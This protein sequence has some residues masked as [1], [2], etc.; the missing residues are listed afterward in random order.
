[1]LLIL[2]WTTFLILQ[3]KLVTPSC[4]LG[5]H[6]SDSCSSPLWWMSR[7]P[8]QPMVAPHKADVVSQCGLDTWD[9]T[10]TA[11]ISSRK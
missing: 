1:M 7:L 9:H 2:L 10:R 5:A 8:S 6:H 4:P 3:L 11:G